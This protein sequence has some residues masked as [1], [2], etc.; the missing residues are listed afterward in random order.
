LCSRN[1]MRIRICLKKRIGNGIELKALGEYHPHVPVWNRFD[2]SGFENPVETDKIVQ[3]TFFFHFSPIFIDVNVWTN[4]RL[5]QNMHYD[6]TKSA[7]LRNLW[8]LWWDRWDLNPHSGGD[9]TRNSIS[10][11]TC[12]KNVCGI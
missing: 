8:V 3:S 5:I 7:G 12:L 11:L 1:L 6:I 9:V 4:F 10:F 2:V